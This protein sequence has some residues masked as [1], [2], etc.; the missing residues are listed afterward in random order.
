MQ[1][2]TPLDYT[3]TKVKV[4]FEI[5]GSDFMKIEYLMQN[6]GF[7]CESD[8]TRTEYGFELLIAIQQ[9]PEV[10][11]VLVDNNH[12]IYQIIRENKNL[13]N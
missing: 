4:Y 5:G 7:L 10:A 8:I 9:I 6:I 12:A 11:K 2:G 13:K 3:D 1:T